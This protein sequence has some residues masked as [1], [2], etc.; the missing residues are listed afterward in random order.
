[1]SDMLSH[2]IHASFADSADKR[3]SDRRV[4]RLEAW[5]ASAEGE[6]GIQVH[7]LSRSGLLIEGATG[8]ATGSELEIELPG[9]T[10]HRAEVVWADDTLFG[11]RFKRA[12]TKAQLS[13]ALLRSAPAEP[14]LSTA[15]ERL[16]SLEA[17][18]KLRQ[19][20]DEERRPEPAA[21]SEHRLPLG[22]RLWI[23]GGLGLAGWALFAGAVWMLG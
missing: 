6:A 23:I 13:A 10:R 21:T 16:T 12:L 1:M 3:A 2:A 20:W 15:P 22:I 14:A 11:C 7:N 4:L 19:N 9:G 17:M 8:V 18:V 5:V